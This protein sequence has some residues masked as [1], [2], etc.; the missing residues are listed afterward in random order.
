MT[1]EGGKL[2]VC[3]ASFICS[4]IN[5]YYQI[6][7]FIIAY[8]VCSVPEYLP[9]KNLRESV[10]LLK[11][12]IEFADGK[13]NSSRNRIGNFADSI[14]INANT[15]IKYSGVKRNYRN[16]KEELVKVFERYKNVS[17]VSP[18]I[19]SDILVF[20]R[21][22]EVVRNATL[23]KE[24]LRNQ[25]IAGKTNDIEVVRKLEVLTKKY[26]LYTQNVDYDL[27]PELA[28]EERDTLNE[29]A[30]SGIDQLKSIFC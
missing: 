1:S 8:T 30:K 4:A 25:L 13:L 2:R 24:Q 18:V 15:L 11:K 16:A 23:A 21:F 20:D 6:S 19:S 14:R 7:L 9:G 26:K 22:L 28:K 12:I 29:K 10:A 5:S 27:E 3:R 17:Y